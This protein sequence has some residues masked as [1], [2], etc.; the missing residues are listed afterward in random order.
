MLEEA[1]DGYAI[2]TAGEQPET[3]RTLIDHIAI[4]PFMQCS[5]ITPWRGD[6]DGK[7]MSDHDGVSAEV[8]FRK[9]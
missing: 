8:S 4:S 5:E 3:R 6:E 9:E 2:A 7:K 1:F